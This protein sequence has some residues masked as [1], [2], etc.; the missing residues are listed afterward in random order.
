MCS[1]TVSLSLAC[2]DSSSGTRASGCSSTPIEITNTIKDDHLPIYTVTRSVPTSD[3]LTVTLKWVITGSDASS[4]LTRYLGNPKLSEQQVFASPD[5]CYFHTKGSTK[6]G[7]Y[8][9]K[10]LGDGTDP[11]STPAVIV[12]DKSMTVTIPA[13]DPNTNEPGLS[14]SF[15][16]D[17]FRCPDI[18]STRYGANSGAVGNPNAKVGINIMTTSDNEVMFDTIPKVEL[19]IKY[20]NGAVNSDN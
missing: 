20:E 19:K 17:P 5:G 12:A 4:A 9:F 18:T 2:K 14:V 3:P 7:Y 1:S 16:L 13:H 6:D 11:S 10:F 15:R 8:T